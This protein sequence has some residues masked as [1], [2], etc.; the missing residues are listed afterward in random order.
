MKKDINVVLSLTQKSWFITESLVKNQ[1]DSGGEEEEGEGEEKEEEEV[2]WYSVL[3][4]NLL[5][6]NPLPHDCYQV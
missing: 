3:E 1:P 5:S 4:E 2:K 6:G